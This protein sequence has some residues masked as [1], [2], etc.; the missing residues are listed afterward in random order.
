MRG[1]LRLAV[2]QVVLVAAFEG[3]AAACP[4]CGGKGASG[5]LENLVLV[6]GFWFGARALMRA[7]KRRRMREHPSEPE[8]ADDPSSSAPPRTTH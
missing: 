6:A 3:L 5:P 8:S 2:A 4:F 7:M 1:F